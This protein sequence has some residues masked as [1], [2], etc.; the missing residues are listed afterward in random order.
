MVE[1]EAVLRFPDVG[2]DPQKLKAHRERPKIARLGTEKSGLAFFRRLRLRN[3]S[4]NLFTNRGFVLFWDQNITKPHCKGVR[5]GSSS[6][7]LGA[8]RLGTPSSVRASNAQRETVILEARHR[9][10]G[11]GQR[12]EM[13]R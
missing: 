10:E 12:W 5:R 13:R 8:T 1:V 6:A 3:R 9:H 2:F 11:C 7:N 4:Y